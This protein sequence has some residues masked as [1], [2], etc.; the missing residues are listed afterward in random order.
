MLCL[1]SGLAERE[2]TNPQFSFLKETHSLF[3]FFTSLCDAYSSALMPPKDLRQRLH[4]DTTSMCAA[5]SEQLTRQPAMRQGR[6]WA[7][8]GMQ[9]WR[10][11]LWPCGSRL[12]S[13]QAKHCR[14]MPA[15]V[16]RWLCYAGCATCCQET[17]GC[18]C[19]GLPCWSAPCRGWSGT[20]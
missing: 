18:L 5:L 20:G 11:V 2:R 1:R 13:K 10:P 15:D 4:S 3:G 9:S 17:N 14:C 8:A 7:A 12:T 6:C 16:L 19:A